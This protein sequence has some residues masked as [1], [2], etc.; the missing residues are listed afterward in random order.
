[1]NFYRLPQSAT[2][3]VHNN[4]DK[5]QAQIKLTN[6]FKSFLNSLNDKFLLPFKFTLCYCLDFRDRVI[7]L[8][9]PLDFQLF[10]NKIQNLKEGNYPLLYIINLKQDEFVSKD[11]I[12]DA[13]VWQEKLSKRYSQLSEDNQ[14]IEQLNEQFQHVSISQIYHQDETE[15]HK[16][17]FCYQKLEKNNYFR[18][19]VCFFFQICEKC[20]GLRREKEHCA[21]HIFILCNNFIDWNKL[22]QHTQIKLMDQK[23][24]LMKKFKIHKKNIHDQII[25]DYCYA[26]PIYNLRYYCC[27][28]PDFDLCKQ[29]LKICKHDQTHNFVQLTMNIEYLIFQ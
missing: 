26:K 6:D 1:M 9:C 22:K 21:A 29:C 19:I 10:L 18:C 15:Y 17:Q 11:M 5:E 16:C 2:I 13:E 25:C 27:E 3:T 12:Q 7:Y 24:K 14:E 23:N 8:A 20:N 28:C 4:I